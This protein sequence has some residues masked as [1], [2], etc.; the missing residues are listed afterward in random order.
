M[1]TFPKGKNGDMDRLRAESPSTNMITVI[2]P[3]RHRTSVGFTDEHMFI[4]SEHDGFWKTYVWTIIN[5]NIMKQY[6]L[7]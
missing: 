5:V 3:K 2:C 6:A 7:Q 4:A 1:A